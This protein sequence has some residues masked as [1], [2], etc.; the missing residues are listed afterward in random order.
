LVI[1]ILIANA[2]MKFIALL[3]KEKC[4]VFAL[5]SASSLYAVLHCTVY[6]HHHAVANIAERSLR[7]CLQRKTTFF[8]FKMFFAPLETDSK[9]VHCAVA[10]GSMYLL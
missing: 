2:G 4:N 9:F 5:V 3:G 1:R 10:N 7:P 6:G 8:G